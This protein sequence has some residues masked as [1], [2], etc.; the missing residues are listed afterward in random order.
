MTTILFFCG[1]MTGVSL[2]ILFLG[3]R[4]GYWSNDRP[5]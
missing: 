1:F 5:R 4:T 2:T 3:W